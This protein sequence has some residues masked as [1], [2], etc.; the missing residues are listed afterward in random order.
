MLAEGIGNLAR[1]IGAGIGQGRDE[2]KGRHG[3]Q[4]IAVIAGDIGLRQAGVEGCN[5]LGHAPL[6]FLP[7][8]PGKGRLGGE[9]VVLHGHRLV[10]K[11]IALLEQPVGFRNAR[12]TNFEEGQEGG[13]EGEDEDEDDREAEEIRHFAVDTEPG[14]RDEECGN[15]GDRQEERQQTLGKQH[16]TGKHTFQAHAARERRVVLEG[17]FPVAGRAGRAHPSGLRERR[18]SDTAD[19]SRR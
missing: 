14:K 12:Q 5:A 4:G 2:E 7:E 19:C 18:A 8:C 3:A 11:A 10:S 6:V 17:A 15:A 1:A 13:D 16:G 9:L